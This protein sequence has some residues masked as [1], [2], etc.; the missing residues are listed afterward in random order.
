MYKYYN[1]ELQT[2]HFVK[3]LPLNSSVQRTI[4]NYSKLTKIK[5]LSS[6]IL[7]DTVKL[8]TNNILKT[9]LFWAVLLIVLALRV[10][11][12]LDSHIMLSQNMVC[13]VLA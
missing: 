2:G 7:K 13:L 8:A 9:L 5:N 4:L 1:N 6:D 10:I 12:R 11:Y 3:D